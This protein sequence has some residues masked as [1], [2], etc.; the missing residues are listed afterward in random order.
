MGFR[1]RERETAR[2]S[3]RNGSRLR[4]VVLGDSFTWGH[5][6]EDEGLFTRLLED[7]LPGTEVWNLGG[8]AY[9]T[10]QELLLLRKESRRI[11][12]C[13]R[14]PAVRVDPEHDLAQAPQRV[15]QRSVPCHRTE[16]SQGLEAAWGLG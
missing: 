5:G 16:R 1:D 7:R 4:I 15:R 6:V 10:E 13:A 14:A 11:D 2:G 9:S 3:D 12:P 8:S